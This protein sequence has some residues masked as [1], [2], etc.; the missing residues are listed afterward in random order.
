V[1]NQFGFALTA[2]N[3]GRTGE[4]DLAIGVL[5]ENIGGI[6]FAGAVNVIYGTA[7]G[8]ASTGNQFWHQNSTGVPDSAEESDSF[9]SSLAP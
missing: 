3:F 5:G 8:L 7:S 6:G 2:G 9:G 1:L 4:A